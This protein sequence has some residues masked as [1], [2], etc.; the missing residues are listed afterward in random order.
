[1]SLQDPSK[2]GCYKEFDKC[3]F[4]IDLKAGA[5]VIGIFSI[6]GAIA[7]IVEMIL[8]FMNPINFQILAIATLGLCALFPAIAYCM[9]LQSTSPETKDRFALWYLLGVSAGAT[10]YFIFFILS[11]AWLIG[12]ITYVIQICIIWYFYCC[13]KSY[14]SREF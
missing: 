8:Y 9:M 4:C 2:A 13:L 3:C 1:M 11:F 10:G 5:H 7:G 12:L 6:L 14:A